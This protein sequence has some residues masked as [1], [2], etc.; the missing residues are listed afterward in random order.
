MKN[1]KNIKE[2][3]IICTGSFNPITKGHALMMK[4]AIDSINADR[5]L[6]FIT[7][8][9]YLGYKM[10]VKK[11]SNFILSDDTRIKMIESLNKEYQNIFY[12]GK[13]VGSGSPSVVKTVKGFLRWNKDNEVYI[14]IGA[15]KLRKLPKWE[16]IDSIIE[17]IKIIIAVRKGFDI[18]QI[19]DDDEW[20]KKYQERFIIIHP[21]EEAFD[22]SSS[23]LREKFFSGESY[24]ELMNEG[25]Y[26]IFKHYS[27]NDFNQL[28]DEERIYY[29]LKY[30]SRFRT[31]SACLLVYKSN[32]KIFK[33]WDVNLLG[34]KEAK[35]KN[36]KVYKEEFITNYHFNYNTIYECINADCADVA[37]DLINKGYRPAILNLA[38]NISPGGGYH[39]GTSAQEEC[40]CQMSTL[41]QSLYQFGDLKC[42][43]IKDA[44]L[45]N[46]PDVYPLDINFGGIYSPDVVFF[47]HNR[48]LNFTLRDEVFSSAIITVAS[49]SNR[50]KNAYTNDE[51]KYFNNDGT[52]TEEGKTIEK[53]KI[54]TIFRI[55][56]DNG[57]DSV[58]LGAFGCGVFNLLPSEV[59]KMFYDVLNEPEFKGNF[60]I[61]S[62]AILERK[63]K[64]GFKIGSNG[65][66]KPFYDL[67][68]NN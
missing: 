65:K 50:E 9:Q 20:F 16:E 26:E 11:K 40:L 60:K 48:S 47:R 2:K 24:K 59:S 22:I 23:L 41:S 67:F 33:N 18:D 35:L 58:V 63:A 32:E 10:L 46:Y 6:F 37:K 15:D 42:Q 57:H 28:T 7:P 43:H 19:I 14:L 45:P 53:N 66:F 68:S 64:K 4:F 49:L 13:E 29:E 25:P 3:V 21:D 31:N 38:S 27:P 54:K 56:L 8:N 34:D 1:S 61:I 12:G 30:N 39:N 52:M 5:G 55:A 36:T 44:D 62:F 17:T 51:R